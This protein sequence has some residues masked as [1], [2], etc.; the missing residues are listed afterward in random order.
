MSYT[1]EINKTINYENIS[2]EK[3]N[4]ILKGKNLELFKKCI[5]LLE[6]QNIRFSNEIFLPNIVYVLILNHIFINLF[7]MYIK[8]QKI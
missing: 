3:A 5:D 6:D 1:N 2:D 4:E 8:N 7:L